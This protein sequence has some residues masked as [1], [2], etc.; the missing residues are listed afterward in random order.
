[1]NRI[2]SVKDAVTGYS[3]VDDKIYYSTTNGIFEPLS[4]SPLVSTPI[5]KINWS[6]NGKAL[7]LSQGQWYLYDAALIK[8][9]KMSQSGDSAWIN[10]KGNFAFFYAGS[11]IKK[12]EIE[13]NTE[14]SILIS[15][16]VD[17]LLFS[18]GNHFAVVGTRNGSVFVEVYDY[19][20]QKIHE[21]TIEN[22]VKVSDLSLGGDVLLLTDE[23]KNTV[24]FY[25][26]RGDK[27][28]TVSTQKKSTLAAGWIDPDIVLLVETKKDYYDRP[29]DYFSTISVSGARSFLTNSMPI[30]G[31]V[32][33]SVRVVGNPSRTIIPLPEKGGGMWILS[34]KESF[35]PNYSENGAT[36]FTIKGQDKGI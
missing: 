23:A 21:T 24:T 19:Y 11:Q 35:M 6:D 20:F 3:W 32:D 14:T 27:N 34:L 28:I 8:N 5:S 30:A 29:I 2:N 13:N 36:F 12:V 22:K 7:Y 10:E 18:P 15:G 33:L 1:L 16:N 17:S 4:S 26:L 31:R 25:S 9:L